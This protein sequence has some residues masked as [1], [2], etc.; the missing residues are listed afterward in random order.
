MFDS[1]FK[2]EALSY[3]ELKLILERNSFPEE[4]YFDISYSPIRERDGT[5]SGVLAIVSE[6]TDSVKIRAALENSRKVMH[7]MI[8]QSPVAM[9]IFRGPDH[10][11]EIANTK[12]LEVWG[13]TEEEALNKPIFE[14]LPEAGKE[15][16][17][18]LMFDV[19]SSGERFI[20][21][22]LPVSLYR[23]GKVETV[24]VNFVYE[25]I[26]KDDPV[27]AGVLSVA[28]DVTEQVNARQKV[29][30]T[31]NE[32]EISNEAL[33][34]FAYIAS[35]DLQEPVRKISTF[36]QML[37]T[38]IVDINSN[39]KRYIEKIYNSTDRMSALIRDVLSYSRVSRIENFET[40]DLNKII[41]GVKIDFELLI[42]QLQ[43]EI[44]TVNLPSLSAI[45]SQMTQLFD[46]LMSNSLKYR[47][48]DVKPLIKISS[49]ILQDIGI[50]NQYRLD[51]D[52]IYYHIKF[53]DNGIGFDE[54]HKFK[55]F[56]IFQRLHGKMEYG[57]TGIGL[58]IC[59]KIVQNHK[60]HIYAEVGK[61]GGAEF[62]ILL[63]DES[64]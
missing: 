33:A 30:Q 34:Q 60:G 28:I 26:M 24:Y 40:V 14:V 63:P 9:A 50:V 53:S 46:N 10:I 22:E 59:E 12:V 8:T 44:E 15:G 42:E 18:K 51:R 17:K 47:N 55:I 61:N 57:G 58:A 13:R 62:N 11:V 41:A 36:T 48:P 35:H 5:V 32:L 39:S 19:Y 1:V 7:N 56:K 2:G 27:N 31:N 4:C 3:N 20:A 29:E 45:S 49:Q 37:E 54:A 21:N 38:S 43:A 23:N 16:L 52:R 6:V 25:P 64:K